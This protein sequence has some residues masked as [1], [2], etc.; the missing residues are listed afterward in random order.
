VH[1]TPALLCAVADLLVAAGVASLWKTAGGSF[2]RETVIAEVGAWP[3]QT[4][5]ECGGDDC[6]A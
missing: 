6:A 2:A 5:A 1:R 3:A 4:A